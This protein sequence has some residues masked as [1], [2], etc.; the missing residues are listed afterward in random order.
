VKKE[1]GSRAAALCAI[2]KMSRACQGAALVRSNRRWLA[3]TAFRWRHRRKIV[4]SKLEQFHLER[5]HGPSQSPI[6]RT[7]K[8]KSP[9]AGVGLETL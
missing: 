9:Y 7:S 4:S 8:R 2:K 3:V 6:D 1:R 5:I